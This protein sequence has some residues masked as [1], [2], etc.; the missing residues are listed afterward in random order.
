MFRMG[1]SSLPLSHRIFQTSFLGGMFSHLL[2]RSCHFSF[3]ILALGDS[4]A[5]SVAH[6]MV[7]VR[8]PGLKS[9]LCHL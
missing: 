7:S 9:L 3:S 4:S 2:C 8:P 5:G 1:F 6:V